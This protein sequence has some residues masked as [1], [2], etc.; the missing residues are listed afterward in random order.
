[1]ILYICTKFKKI[2]QIISELSSTHDFYTEI[3][4]G[5]YFVKTASGV[6]VLV[7]CMS[8][9]NAIYLN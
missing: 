3:Y 4:K 1:M 9:D 7:L 6:M 8:S 5:A 2:S